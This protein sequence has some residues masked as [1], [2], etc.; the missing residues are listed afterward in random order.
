MLRAKP[1]RDYQCLVF[2]GMRQRLLKSSLRCF[3]SFVG[4]LHGLLGVLVAGLVIFLSVAN[5]RGAMRVRG[6]FV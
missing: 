3:V 4:V 1:G 2:S 6:L 5:R